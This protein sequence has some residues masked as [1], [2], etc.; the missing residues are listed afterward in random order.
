MRAY[1]YNKRLFD[2]ILE[3]YNGAN[4]VPKD[5]MPMPDE[6]NYYISS[7]QPNYEELMEKLQLTEEEKEARV[8]DDKVSLTVPTDLS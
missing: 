1:C 8:Q 3:R 7:K 5:R 4:P 6:E 2:A